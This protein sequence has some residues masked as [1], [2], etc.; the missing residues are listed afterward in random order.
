MSLFVVRHQHESARCPARD[1]QMGAML[2][3]H[4][5]PSQAATFGVKV[6]GE[7]VVD[8]QHTLYLILEAPDRSRVEAFLEPVRRAGSLE[9]WPASPC[10]RIVERGGC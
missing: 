6:H 10:E 1:P 2:L 3:A 7:A 8:G 4:L 9:I 5:Q